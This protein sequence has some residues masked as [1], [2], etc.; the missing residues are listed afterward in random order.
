VLLEE[1]KFANV[2]IEEVKS[3]YL[4]FLLY[5]Y[6]FVDAFNLSPDNLVTGKGQPGITVFC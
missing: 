2:G 3:H 5:R 1:K 4:F 6:A